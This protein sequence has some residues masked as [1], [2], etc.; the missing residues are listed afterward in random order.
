MGNQKQRG[1]TARTPSTN[2]EAASDTRHSERCL[3]SL[4]HTNDCICIGAIARYVHSV[5]VAVFSLQ[6]SGW[7][8][9]FVAFGCKGS[10]DVLANVG[11]RAEDENGWVYCSGYTLR[12]KE[13]TKRKIGVGVWRIDDRE[14]VLLCVM[15]LIRKRQ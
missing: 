11:A 13:R 12:M 7:D 3:H 15:L 5:P 4:K 9:C 6:A 1:L 2:Y 14:D 8:G 10:C